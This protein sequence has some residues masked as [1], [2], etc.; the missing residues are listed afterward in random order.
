MAV[1]AGQNRGGLVA[2]VLA[3]LAVL[4]VAWWLA[5]AASPSIR[6]RFELDEAT[7]EVLSAFVLAD[8]VVAAGGAAL[9]ALAVARGWSVA[10]SV[11]AWTAGGWAYAT[12]LLAGWVLL[13]GG[14]AV[15]LL[16]MVT[17]T[18]IVSVLA[19]RQRHEG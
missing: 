5:M 9:G 7:P 12:L 3:G 13:G 17:A 16:P 1:P 18:G 11:L 14:G 6:S 8:L 15:G 2:A 4:T 10:S 19:W